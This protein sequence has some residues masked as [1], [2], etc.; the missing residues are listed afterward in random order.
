MKKFLIAVFCL[1]FASQL[2]AITDEEIFRSI[3]LNLSTPGA[4][5]RAMGGAFIGRADDAT[6]AETNPAGLT[7]LVKPEISLEYRFQNNQT[8]KTTVFDIPVAPG[9]DITPS[10]LPIP[11][12][13]MENEPVSAEFQ[14]V[15][16]Q[17]SV[18]EL[19]FFSVVYPFHGISLAFSRFELINTNATVRGD[20][21]SS[22]FHYV[23]RNGFEGAVDVSDVKYGF[24]GAFRLG[25]LFS[26]GAGL[27]VCDFSFQSNIGAFQKDEQELGAHFRTL[28][29][30]SDIGIGFNA[31]VLIRPDAHISIGAV[32]RYEPSFDLDVNVINA[33]F[34][35]SPL[36]RERSGF[37]TVD[38]D[39]PDTV[40]LGVSIAPTP[41]V[42][43]NIDV[44]R[45]FYSQLEG[46]ETG[47]SLFTHLLPI[48]E[49]A[50]QITFEVEDK[51]DVHVGFEYLWTT[52]H[53]VVAFRAGYYRQGRNRF[54]LREAVNPDIEAFLNPIFGN[55]P[56]S[57]INHLTFGGGV[58]RGNFSL[59]F[60]F[61][62]NQKNEVDEINKQEI[63]DGGFQFILSSVFRF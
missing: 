19:G 24:T 10:P 23:E 31:G 18:N 52:T 41:N 11:D 22:P 46:V 51:T 29:D 7:I 34:G 9:Y 20:I 15:D 44:V 1:G 61:D 57:G 58:T 33:D 42:N 56:G 53:D 26:F 37:S 30:T 32:Y 59:D 45:I 40:G 38:F 36:I 16:N 21:S 4:R 62:L 63:T 8:V 3:S 6:A 60:A 17:E 25:S 5:A 39:V 49:N 48:F 54:F 27:E 13:G 28:V 35:G 2:L 47:Y 14:A 12:P 43:I 50:D 55:N